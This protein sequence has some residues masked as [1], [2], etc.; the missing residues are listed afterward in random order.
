[1]ATIIDSLIVTL[2]LDP[3][4][5]TKGG[6]QADAAL[7]KTK[8]QAVK[9]G[10][11]IEQAAKGAAEFLG[12]VRNQALALFAAFEAG[13]GVKAF[14]ADVTAGDVALG[15]M[16]RSIGISTQTLSTWQGAAKLAGGSAEGIAG[17][18]QTLAD[19][20]TQ[21]KTTGE[22]SIIPYLRA[23]SAAG[24]TVID[25]RKPL[26]DTFLDIADDL[27]K[28]ARTD[29]QQ[30][31][32]IAR[33]IGADPATAALLVQGRANLEAL[34]ATAKKFAATDADR[35][36]ASKRLEAWRE[37]DGT[38]TSVGRTILTDLTPAI[39]GVVKDMTDW[40]KQNR[41]WIQTG[42]VGAIK[43]FI[44]WLRDPETKK[45]FNDILTG[46][47]SAID[48]VGGLTNAIEILF[49]LWIGSKFLG[50][51]GSIGLVT[52]ALSSGAAAGGLWGLAI[53]AAIAAAAGA[54][55]LTWV[56]AN[57]WKEKTGQ[58]WPLI[59]PQ[60][61]MPIDAHRFDASLDEAYI[62]E[63]AEKRHIDPRVA[64]AVAKTEGLG[65]TYAGDQ[66][67]SFGPYQLHVGGIAP[68]GNSV[69]GL[70]DEFQKRTGLDPRKPETVHAQIEFALDYARE[71][72]WSSWHGWKGDE[73]AGL[74]LHLPPALGA[75]A[76]A[77]VGD[78]TNNS[79]STSTNSSA[80]T[81]NGPI[82][83][84]TQATDA[85]GMASGLAGALG[86]YMGGANFNFGAN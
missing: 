24:G 34:L 29:P 38:L 66:G 84:T 51:L 55:I 31:N 52:R 30:A 50:M 82:T 3:S 4:G 27:Q 41:E 72:G 9:S 63:Q 78:T 60:S 5:F 32:W 81:I 28:L 44:K 77:A 62:R 6:K 85:G 80:V 71:H 1:M 20:I 67:S 2:G 18:F 7:V 68:G 59:D 86:R 73:W 43:E 15:R 36:A 19:N 46:I 65:T 42:I 74:P 13:R 22:S 33:Q 17:T 35:D 56:G 23:L 26:N 75:P 57:K 10:K 14:V 45:G 25:L 76:L 40:V 16:A 21:F 11:E 79:N 54:G 64:V 49:A 53:K 8:Q 48:A 61:G 70:G 69:G 47:K 83:V 37:L 39:D 58:D 12:R